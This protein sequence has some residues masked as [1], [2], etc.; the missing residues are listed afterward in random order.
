MDDPR[1]GFVHTIVPNELTRVCD[2]STTLIPVSERR[3]LG[4]VEMDLTPSRSPLER[5]HAQSNR[6]LTRRV[7]GVRKTD[8]LALDA[9]RKAEHEACQ[10]DTGSWRHQSRE[11]KWRPE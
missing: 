10:A 6:A 2:V 1:S 4:L 5:S 8:W 11:V 9:K 7:R 3:R